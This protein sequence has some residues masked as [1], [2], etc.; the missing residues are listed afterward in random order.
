MEGNMR[1]KISKSKNSESLYIIKS[2]YIKG[3]NT[4]KI[5]EKLG[6]LQEVIDKANGE[7][8]Y[9]WAKKRAKFLTEQEVKED[10]Q[11]LVNF[12]PRKTITSDKQVTFNAGYLFLQKIYHDLG[13]H[14]ICQKIAEKYR[15]EYDLDSILSRIVYSRMLFPASKLATYQL[16]KKYLEQ[17]NFELHQIYRALEVI[18]K[19]SDRIQAQL[20]KNSLKVCQRNSK[21]L[22]YDCTNY[23]FEIEEAQ[24]I[25]QYGKSKENRP[26]PIVQMGLF[27]DGNGLPLAFTMTPGNQ[28]EQTT[29]RPLEKKLLRDFKMAQFVVC[30]DAGLSATDNRKYND[31][32]KRAFITT[33]SLKKLKA[34]LMEWAL[35]DDGWRLPQNDEEFTISQ[36][37][38][39]DDNDKTYYKEAWIQEDGLEQR[40]IVTY[41]L[42]YKNYQEKIRQGQIERALKL[43]ADGKKPPKK[44]HPH[45]V[46]R[47]IKEKNLTKEGEIA[48][49][50]VFQLDEAQIQN[51]AKFDGFYGVCTNLTDEVEA[52][53]EINSGRWE[54]EESFRI[55]KSEF[56][57]RPVNLRKDE[58][59]EAHFTTCFIALV[60][61][62]ML[63]KRLKETYTTRQIL[64]TLR[65]MNLMAIHGEGYVPLYQRTSLTDDLHD[66]FGFH[67]DFEI[68]SEKNLKKIFKQTKSG[69]STVF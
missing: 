14:K 54:I 49:Q 25:K 40:L 47:F 33:Q 16:S 34:P 38:E 57:A 52:I 7:D 22:Y 50:T 18:Y 20:Y 5:V 1:V 29:L 59:I 8:P 17:P 42:K 55:M 60:I 48:D 15:F 3:K 64:D 69:K 68:N 6:T 23:F 26:N 31:M 10:N 39:K 53:I 46:R 32:G 21:V 66:I 37:K 56:K 43:M 44:K 45:D 28:N 11:V 41:S 19:E 67:T 4:S 35:R 61:Q 36:I 9:L 24:G 12:S 58:R 13:L 62:R 30:T 51:E 2:V 27:M 65:E 63:E